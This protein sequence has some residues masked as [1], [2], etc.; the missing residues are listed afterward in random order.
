MEKYNPTKI[1]RTCIRAGASR[2]DADQIVKQ[3]SAR[4][5]NG[6]STQEILYMT[7]ALLKKKVPSV[8]LKY[9]LKGAIMRIGPAGFVFEEMIAQILQEHGYTAKVHSMIKGGS[10]VIHEIDV[11]AGKSVSSQSGIESNIKYYSIECKYHN[12]PGIYTGLKDV[13]YTYA[14]FLDLQDGFKK[15]YGPRFDQPWLITNTKFSPDVKQYAVAKGMRLLSWDYPR[16]ESLPELIEAKKLYPITMLKNLDSNTQGNLAKANIIFCKTL[17]ET[18][19]EKL[20][21]KTGI[22][23]RKLNE[24]IEEARRIIQ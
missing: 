21:Q 6:T 17:I 19:V 15:G 22:S 16:G 9:D 18:K 3:V 14:R 11:I 23:I 5:K 10:G 12:S 24:F 1:K 4:V 13:L 2:E 8:G 7:L 20:N